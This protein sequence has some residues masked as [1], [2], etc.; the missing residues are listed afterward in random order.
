MK[1]QGAEWPIHSPG[2]Y[3]SP[4]FVPLQHASFC[5]SGHPK[6]LFIAIFHDND[7]SWIWIPFLSVLATGVSYLLFSLPNFFVLIFSFTF[8]LAWLPAPL[9]LAL[10]SSFLWMSSGSPLTVMVTK[11]HGS[12]R[13]STMRGIL[14]PCQN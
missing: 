11:W 7:D 4:F 5:I 9:V 3:E 1:G 13:C 6:S 8:L 2:F 10:Y 12:R 14:K